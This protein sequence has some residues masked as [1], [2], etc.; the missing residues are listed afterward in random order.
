MNQRH[1]YSVV[2]E[3]ALKT[4]KMLIAIGLDGGGRKAIQV[5]ECPSTEVP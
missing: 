5:G 1:R 4:V 3:R 2:G